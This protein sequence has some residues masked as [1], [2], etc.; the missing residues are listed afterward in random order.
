MRTQVRT[1]DFYKYLSTGVQPKIKNLNKIQTVLYN[2]RSDHM[3]EC[4]I[5]VILS[6]GTGIDVPFDPYLETTSLSNDSDD[7]HF[8][9]SHKSIITLV[10]ETNHTLKM[11]REEEVTNESQQ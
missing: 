7:I 9:I 3:D 2:E 4:W 8:T 11:I 10:K 5:G 1:N 6:D